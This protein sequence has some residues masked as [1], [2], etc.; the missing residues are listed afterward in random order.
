MKKKRKK[1][2]G[3]EAIKPV[4]FLERETD[5]EIDCHGDSI[6]EAMYKIEQQLEAMQKSHYSTLRV[7]HGNHRA[8]E[9]TIY[10][11]MRFK[12]S[13]CWNNMIK[14]S[15]QEP[16]NLGATIIETK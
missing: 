12:L 6:D 7:I 8:G 5:I 4:F 14:R 16:H 10:K 11:E 13:Q 15:Y 3:T 1:K 2:K 9:N